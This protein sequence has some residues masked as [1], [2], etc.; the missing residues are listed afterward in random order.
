[1]NFPTLSEIVLL[2]SGL[3]TSA[4]PQDKF[5]L[6]L[7]DT[8]TIATP[9]VSIVDTTQKSS[10]MPVA[11]AIMELEANGIL[12]TEARALSDRL[13]IEIFKVGIYQVLER[14][15]MNRI[16]D[17]MQFQLSG[18]TSDEC[19]VEVGRIVGVQKIIAGSISKVGEYYSVS[20]RLID[21]ETGKIEATALEDIEGTLGVVLTKA[22]PSVARQIS[23]L[24]REPIILAG[25]KTTF[26]VDTEP[27]GAAIYLNGIYKGVAPLEIEVNYEYSHMLKAVLDGYETWER[28][29]EAR[30]NQRTEINIVLLKKSPSN[31]QSAQLH[32][33][34][35]FN[36]GFKIRYADMRVKDKINHQ[37]DM[38]NSNL[39]SGN[40]LFK[41]NI[42][43][44]NFGQIS[45]FNGIEFYNLRQLGPWL[46][47]DFGLGYYRNNFDHWITDIFKSDGSSDDYRLS[48][49]S[50][51][52]TFNLRFAPI[53]YPLFYPY[54]NIGLGY[55][56]LVIQT[57]QGDKSFGGP[58]YQAWG[59]TYG[60][61][62]E[63]RPF[64]A[65][66]FAVEWLHRR[67]D[68]ELMDVDKVTDRFKHAGLTKIPLG[69]NNV[70]VSLNLY[71]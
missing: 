20:V 5:K 53:R 60:G 61:G 6:N 67:M 57:H 49:I 1:M 10:P 14:E 16:L 22:I 43:T 29:Y 17:E 62:L 63:I 45:H 18:C 70:G 24:S 51:E 3:L 64:K 41:Q 38:I 55:N 69:G 66:G 15:K 11:V 52:L 48:V 37:I 36:Q 42:G 50:P 34:R 23:G 2:I 9:P 68:L 35:S 33:R 12:P 59:M 44:P 46:G 71:Y 30:K 56:L 21:V 19:A 39:A 26:N 4:F 54:F 31:D 7:V 32:P 8:D 47:F 65:I 27:Q 25:Q 40:Q 28:T 13:R 58:L